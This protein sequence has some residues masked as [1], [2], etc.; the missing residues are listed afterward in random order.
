[1]EYAVAGRAS[2]EVNDFLRAWRGG[3]LRCAQCQQ[4]IVGRRVVGGGGLSYHPSHAPR[5]AV[6][7]R[8]ASPAVAGTLIGAA[9]NM[10]ETHG[11]RPRGT[12]YRA[13]ELFSLDC[14]D[15]SLRR[16]GQ[17]LRLNHM[18]QIPGQFRRLAID[19]GS[20]T[21]EFC[22][23][24]SPLGRD[25]LDD[26]RARRVTTCSVGFNR[27]QSRFDRTTEIIQ[28]A[29]LVEISLLRNCTPA[30]PDT[31]VKVAA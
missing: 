27:K 7:S 21:F 22:V 12:T 11:I 1:M 17:Q 6:A 29:E 23:D 3:T 26:V 31:W 14:F 4:P 2:P 24:D 30:L 19:A 5:P 20:L 15:D 13:H 8:A 25:V 28:D 9:V 10:N 18:S 16:G